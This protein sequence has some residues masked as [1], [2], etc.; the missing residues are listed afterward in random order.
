MEWM[1]KINLVIV[2][3]AFMYRLS[4]QGARH[5]L[6]NR[7]YLL[8]VPFV[9]MLLPFT[10]QLT[11]PL[12]P[13]YTFFLQ[14]VVVGINNLNT[15]SGF[16]SIN[17]IMYAYQ[18]GVA[19]AF[20]LFLIRLYNALFHFNTG[21]TAHSFFKRIYLPGT[22]EQERS[23]M[24]LH[25]YAHAR[26]WHSADVLYY[27]LLQ[28]AFWFNPA[29]YYLGNALA[30]VNE[31]SADQYATKHIGNKEAYCELL[32]NETF[33]ADARGVTNPFHSG[34]SIFKRITMIT[35]T[36][37]QSVSGWKYIALIPLLALAL[38]LSGVPYSFA[39]DTKPAK[40]ATIDQLPEFKGDLYKYLASEV[41]YP[42]SARKDKV[43]GRVILQFVVNAQGKIG[44][45]RNVSPK[46]DER[47]VKEAIRVVSAMPDWKPGM[48]KG[49]PV[50]A[51]MTLPID[52]RLN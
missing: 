39:Q 44:S 38:F 32:L 23:M 40:V 36:K 33:G 27:Q 47:L 12:Q 50:S 35:Q 48:N 17:W 26:F 13:V 34:S 10:A 4:L 7:V 52:F 22:G 45:I 15:H 3:M 49:K 31:Y 11:R 25:E 1:I 6:L 30:E 14:P 8:C 18:F 20:C 5:F 9:A 19:I 42:E 29:I 37:T 21:N 41:K 16:S 24:H 51:E 46:A 2:V 43:E 28:C